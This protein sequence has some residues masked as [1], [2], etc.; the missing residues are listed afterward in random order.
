MEYLVV[1]PAHELNING[2]Q[3]MATWGD[4]VKTAV[5]SSVWNFGW[6]V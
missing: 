6:S 5:N 3:A 4:E 2:L 1:E